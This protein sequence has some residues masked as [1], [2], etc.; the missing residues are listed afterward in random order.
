MT[1]TIEED[2]EIDYTATPLQAAQ[3]PPESE[4]LLGDSPTARCCRCKH[5]HF[6]G[7]W[8]G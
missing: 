8:F 2:E 3:D 7:R 6:F 1:F 4:R 5:A